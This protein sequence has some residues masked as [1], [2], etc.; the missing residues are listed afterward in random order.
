MWYTKNMRNIAIIIG[1]NNSWNVFIKLIFC[2]VEVTK[3]KIA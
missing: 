3:L 2:N 1:R